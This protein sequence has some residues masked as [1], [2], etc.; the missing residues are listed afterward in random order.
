MKE[1]RKTVAQEFLNQYH[2]KQD[3][4]LKNTATGDESWVHHYDPEN[5]RQS[6]EY[7]HPGSPNVKKFKTVLSA[8]KVMISIFWD[9]KGRALHGISD[10]RIDGELRQVLC[11]LIITQATH[12]QNQARKK[13]ISFAS[14]QRKATLQCTNSGCHEK[15]EIHSGSTPS[16][17]PRFG[18]VRLLVVPKIEG[19]VKRSTFFIGRQS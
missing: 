19:D 14:S 3:D 17:Q 10:Y 2:L 11:N 1:H 7:S 4:F 13:H 9:A 8:I 6:T 15:P 16:L 5:K 18:T 12:P